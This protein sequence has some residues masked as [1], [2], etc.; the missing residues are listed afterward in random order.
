MWKTQLPFCLAK[1]KQD[2]NDLE[3]VT[4]FMQTLNQKIIS[5]KLGL[6][7]LA[8]EL[9]NI[10]K[11]CR[12]MGTSRDTFYRYRESFA[13]GGIEALAEANR[14]KPNVKNRVEDW[15]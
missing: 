9:Q 6:L 14:K 8:Q 4:E 15:V 7:N 2:Q 13:D 11:A 5:N 12:I 1:N 10:S 3:K